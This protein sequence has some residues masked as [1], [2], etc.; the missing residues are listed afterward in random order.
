MLVV[1]AAAHRD[2]CFES[3]IFKDLKSEGKLSFSN[4]SSAAT[5]FGTLVSEVPAAILYPST[6]NDI[7]DVLKAVYDHEDSKLTVAARGAGHSIFGQALT[8]S[9][10]V[11]AMSHLVS[12]IEI[13]KGDA[14]SLSYADV[15]GGE[16]WV[17]LLQATLKVGSSVPTFNVGVS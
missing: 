2:V 5:D 1:T 10:V 8:R 4:L 16:L 15:G 17:N 6:T 14:G 7:Q 9:G 11:I 13:H 3:P 12:N